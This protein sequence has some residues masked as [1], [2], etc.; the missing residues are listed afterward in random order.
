[1]SLTM[2]SK[3][4]VSMTVIPYSRH[5]PEIRTSYEYKLAR[6]NWFSE[7]IGSRNFRYHRRMLCTKDKNESRL[8]IPAAP[9]IRARALKMKR[10]S[11]LIM[12]IH[13]YM[14]SSC[15]PLG[16]MTINWTK[17]K[18]TKNYKT[19]K[20]LQNWVQQAI[21]SSYSCSRWAFVLF[22]FFISEIKR[23]I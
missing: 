4:A 11:L 14:G 17:N 13:T 7:T 18:S 6:L 12:A 21:L 22:L 8:T 5:M 2:F 20:H 3:L 23:L 15:N 10:A 1:M 19:I 9:Q 16:G